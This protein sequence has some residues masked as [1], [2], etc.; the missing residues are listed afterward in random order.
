M[1]YNDCQATV[2]HLKNNCVAKFVSFNFLLVQFTAFVNTCL[3]QSSIITQ[4]IFAS[5]NN[6]F[7]IFISNHSVTWNLWI[8]EMIPDD[9]FSIPFEVVR[10]LSFTSGSPLVSSDGRGGDGS[11]GLANR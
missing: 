3:L 9:Y 11:F 6:P 1:H 2:F 5:F 4:Y 8:S 7:N 10:G